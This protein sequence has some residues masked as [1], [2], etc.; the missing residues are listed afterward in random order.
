MGLLGAV[1]FLTGGAFTLMGA[2]PVL[3][4]YGLDVALIYLAFRVNY[5]AARAHE[6]VELT[7]E[8]LVLT[9]IG[10]GGEEQARL[11]LN[12]Y[13]ARVILEERSCGRAE[14][15]ILSRGRA[16]AFGHVLNHEE[17]REFANILRA[18]MAE[19]RR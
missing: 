5:R 8:R 7:P 13:W 9:R 4:F 15:K 17:R 6:V 16:H 10:V 2:W 12:P 1:G 19:A 11:E 18:A 3:G 14:L